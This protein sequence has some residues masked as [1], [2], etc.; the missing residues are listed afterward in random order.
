MLLASYRLGRLAFS[1]SRQRLLIV[2]SSACGSDRDGSVSG[3]VA[4]GRNRRAGQVKG[5]ASKR[6]ALTWQPRY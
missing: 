1:L 5:Y 3:S 6:E 4:T 2:V